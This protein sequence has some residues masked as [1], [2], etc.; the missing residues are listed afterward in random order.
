MSFTCILFARARF[1]DR[2][3][4]LER[5]NGGSKPDKKKDDKKAKKPIIQRSEVFNPYCVNC[6]PHL[7]DRVHKTVI[8]AVNH[9]PKLKGRWSKGRCEYVMHSCILSVVTSSWISP[10]STAIGSRS[11]STTGTPAQS[12]LPA[13]T[14][15]CRYRVVCAHIGVCIAMPLIGFCRISLSE[16]LQR[17]KLGVYAAERVEG[18]LGLA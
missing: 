1:N 18:E 10:G 5:G 4:R 2:R 14:S 8:K 6:P 16:P 9:D 3:C 17:Q 13:P 15:G 12:A 7:L 11:A